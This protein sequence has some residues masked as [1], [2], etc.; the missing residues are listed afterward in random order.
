MKTVATTTV[1][2][3][4]D[5]AAYADDMLTLSTQTGISTDNLQAYNY[6]AE[7]TD[8]SMEDMTK[9]MAKNIKSMS[10]AERGTETY[11][12]A[13]KKL[14]VSVTDNNGKLRDSEEVHW[15]SIDALGKMTNETDKKCHCNDFIR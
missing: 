4:A 1:D 3:V 11:T 12:D 14:G 9:S 2:L 15:E 7:L 5:T 13:Y 6:M 10:G 8:V